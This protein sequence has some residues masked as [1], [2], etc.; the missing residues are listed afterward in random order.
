MPNNPASQVCSQH[1]SSVWHRDD[2]KNSCWNK[3]LMIR[4][5]GIIFKTPRGNTSKLAM[6]LCV[7]MKSPKHLRKWTFSCWLKCKWFPFSIKLYKSWGQ[8]DKKIEGLGN[9][10]AIFMPSLK[11][12][13]L[14]LYLRFNSLLPMLLPWLLNGVV[15]QEQ[16]Y[17]DSFSIL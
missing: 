5:P 11:Y 12:L 1:L 4:W 7:D 8:M 17:L 3:C 13:T 15:G 9:V 14:N 2:L 10:P 16:S 6:V